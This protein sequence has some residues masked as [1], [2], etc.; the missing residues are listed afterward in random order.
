MHDGG[1]GAAKRPQI[2]R[3]A[4]QGHIVGHAQSR[5]SRRAASEAIALVKLELRP[6]RSARFEVVEEITTKDQNRLPVSDSRQGAGLDPA[7][8]RPL[9]TAGDARC[10]L[11]RVVTVDFYRAPVG[12]SGALAWVTLLFWL[13]IER[14]RARW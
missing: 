1:A 5:H 11:H 12:F 10:L 14:E 7:P 13:G 2:A 3:G 6:G 9:G 4:R 8:D